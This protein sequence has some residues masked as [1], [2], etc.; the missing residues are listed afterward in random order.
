M[1]GTAVG[2]LVI[3]LSSPILTRLY[4]PE[5]FGILNIYTSILSFLLV[6]CSLRY[7]MAIPIA[8]DEREAIH[9]VIISVM[10]LIIFSFV[11][12][13]TFILADLFNLNIINVLQASKIYYLFPVSLFF[14]GLY[15]IFINWYTRNSNFELITRTKLSQSITLTVFSIVLGGMNLKF[16]GLIFADTIGKSA[17][18]LLML[19]KF[20]N[21]ISWNKLKKITK[22]IYFLD[23]MKK[24]KHYPLITTWSSLL[25]VASIYLS[26]A[27]F[28]LSFNSTIGGYF[29]FGH[30]IVGTPILLIG[31][32]ISQVYMSVFSR[33]ENPLYIFKKIV[34]CLSIVGIILANILFFYGEFL[35]SFIFGES[36]RISGKYVGI[37]SFMYLFYIV[38][39]PVSQT[40]ILIGKQWIQLFWDLSRVL[41]ICILFLSVHI[42]S[43]SSIVAIKIYSIG[44]GIFY[45]ILLFLIHS[46][47][48]KEYQE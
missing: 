42:F 23:T 14:I 12:T 9:L 13:G 44:M 39:F 11:V 25:N 16:K 37:L 45:L 43:L 27:L 3:F 41:F 34:F 48:K 31:Q 33:R 7:E 30:K 46:M 18:A 36:W 21:Q 2:Q 26:P 4:S 28:T 22:E 6:L 38:A 10:I 24:Y 1:S 32:S 40:L 35:F 29:S 15:Q 5:D 47:L 20:I 19:R 17:G 8:E